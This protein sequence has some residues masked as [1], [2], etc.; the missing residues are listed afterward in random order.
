MS[1]IYRTARGNLVNM[2]E[3]R[4][5]NETRVAAG[6]MKVNARGDELG[7]G[8]HIVRNLADRARAAQKNLKQTKSNTS[9]KPSI[10]QSEKT[11]VEEPVATQSEV[12]EQPDVVEEFDTEGN[13]TIKKST[14]GK[15]KSESKSTEE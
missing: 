10:T 7:S 6:N 5:A 2:D 13:I 1:K 12:A 14:K 11:I 9:I 3:L 4:S 8:G 15:N